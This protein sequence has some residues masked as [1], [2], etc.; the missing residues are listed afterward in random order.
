MRLGSGCTRRVS[1]RKR[2]D[3]SIDHPS[4]ST[5]GVT[6]MYSPT[7][8]HN[9]LMIERRITD[10]RKDQK[11]YTTTRTSTLDRSVRVRRRLAYSSFFGRT[12]MHACILSDQ[13]CVDKV[14]S[15]LSSLSLTPSSCRLPARALIVPNAC[16][17]SS[18]NSILSI[19]YTKN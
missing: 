17:R 13:L 9:E 3:S 12:C 14:R 10:D 2:R 4:V 1:A 19:M 6:A 5:M 15:S 7:P 18:I 11:T 16:L 8:L